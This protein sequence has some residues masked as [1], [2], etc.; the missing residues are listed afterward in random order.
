MVFDQGQ[1]RCLGAGRYRQQCQPNEF[2]SLQNLAE[3][4]DTSDT[5]KFNFLQRAQ[6][7]GSYANQ[8]KI[9]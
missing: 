5:K 4:V 9:L 6:V 1:D 8:I 7:R 3:K 2:S